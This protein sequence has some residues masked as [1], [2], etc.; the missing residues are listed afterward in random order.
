MR[1]NVSD[2]E[3][4]RQSQDEPPALLNPLSDEAW[5][6]FYSLYGLIYNVRMPDGIGVPERRY[7]AVEAFCELF[8]KNP[9]LR[10][11]IADMRIINEAETRIDSAFDERY[12]FPLP[13]ATG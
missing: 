2:S 11:I 13:R 4:A 9:E 3:T 1:S 5:N 7:D 6:L 10:R 12:P 8:S